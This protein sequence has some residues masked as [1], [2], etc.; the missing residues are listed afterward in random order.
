MKRIEA[1]LAVTILLWLLLSPAAAVRIKDL[2]DIQ[3]VRSN[4]LVG[5][6]LVIGLDGT[7]DN[8]GTEF[9]IQS[10]VS[11]LKRMGIQVDR[12]KVKVDN[13]AAVMVT[14]DLPPFARAGTRIDALVSSIGDAESLQGGTLVLTSL[15]GPDGLVYAVAQGPVSIG[16]G[17]TVSGAAAKAQK[18]HPTVGRVVNGALI[19]REIPF[20]FGNRREISIN[21]R[22]PDFTT[23]LRLARV[24]N[25]AL[26]GEF[27][28]PID[29]GTVRVELPSEY[30]DDVVGLVASI[31]G[32]DVTPD[33]IAKVVLDE[34]TGTVVIGE[35]VRISAVAISHGN[36]SI[37][38]KERPEVSQPMPFARRGETVVTPKTELRVK[39]EKQ[40]VMLMPEGVSIQE[41]VKALNAIGV[42]PRDLIAIFQALKQA[43]ALQAELE[44][45]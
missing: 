17:F 44:I 22:R 4:Q 9:T 43:G 26:D 3:G 5:Y 7:G 23:A 28:T 16:G 40:K 12:S 39:E 45:M 25:S 34:R 11:M 32:L 13:V 38:I 42:S 41:V 15:K 10:L 20:R 18:N 19:E 8:Q 37:V 35:E 1:L 29:G 24:V 33:R 36:L 6:G 31:E 2:A 30:A 27:A 21:L 14:A